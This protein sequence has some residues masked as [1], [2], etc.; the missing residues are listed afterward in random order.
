MD[1]S[2]I[3]LALDFLLDIAVSL[4]HTTWMDIVTLIVIASCLGAGAAGGLISAWS[5]HR[6][7]L[8]LEETFKI[9]VTSLEDRI[10]Q[11]T[12]IAVRQDKSDAAKV[13]WSKKESDDQKVLSELDKSRVAMGLSNSENHPWDPRT[14]GK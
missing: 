3:I 12:K 5:C 8:V 1:N 14:W 2:G 9:V 6:R 10:E 11:V 4:V 13:R 7:V